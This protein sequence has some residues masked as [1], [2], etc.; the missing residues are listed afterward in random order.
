E[1]RVDALAQQEAVADAIRGRVNV[2]P[3]YLSRIVDPQRDRPQYRVVV[4]H[5]ESGEDAL[6]PDEAMTSLLVSPVGPD[7][8]ALRVEEAALRS[9]RSRRVKRGKDAFAPEI[10]VGGYGLNIVDSSELAGR[11][12]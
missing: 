5:I 4:G 12:D 6:S 2:V 10:G 11:A 1:R 8:L 3:D 9:D 7:N